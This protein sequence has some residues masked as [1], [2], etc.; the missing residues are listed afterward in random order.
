VDD[1][2]SV[3]GVERGAKLLDDLSDEFRRQRT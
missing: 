3:G 2:G 1:T